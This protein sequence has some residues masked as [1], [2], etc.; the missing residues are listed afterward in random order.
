MLG[1]AVH[2]KF[3]MIIIIYLVYSLNVPKYNIE[4]SLAAISISCELGVHPSHIIKAIKSF[5]C[6]KKIRISHK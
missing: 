4:N 6:K 3:I 2:I 5:R 1:E